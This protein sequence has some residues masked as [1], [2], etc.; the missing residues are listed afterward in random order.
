MGLLVEIRGVFRHF[1]I[2]RRRLPLALFAREIGV[3]AGL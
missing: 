3:V 1:L 2:Q